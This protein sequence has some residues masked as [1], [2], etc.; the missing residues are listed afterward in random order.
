M[1]RHQQGGWGQEEPGRPV[2]APNGGTGG[3]WAGKT[4]GG[5]AARAP[6][7]LEVGDELEDLSAICEKFR[8]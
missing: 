2:G 6:A 5:G 3:R 7:K 4:G 8:G 1:K